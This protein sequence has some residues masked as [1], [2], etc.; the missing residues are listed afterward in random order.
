MPF[1]IEIEPLALSA[2]A[3]S[4]ENL[5]EILQ[6]AGVQ[7]EAECGGQGIC[8][9]CAAILLDGV[10]EIEGR[11]V[12][13]GIIKTCQAAVCGDAR[14]KI[15]DYRP[16]SGGKDYSV[17]PLEELHFTV[18]GEFS[19]LT[20]IKTFKLDEPTLEANESDWG[21]L[22][23]AA[24]LRENT[25][26]SLSVL[27]RL[28]Q[29][30]RAEDGR[31]S[32]IISGKSGEERIIDIRA[33]DRV[34]NYGI[35][36]DIGTTTIALHLVDLADGSIVTTVS[37]YNGQ[38]LCGA[39]V[40][41]RIIYAGRQDRLAELRKKAVDTVNNLINRTVTDRNI[42]REEIMAV[43][44]A[45][46][47]TM[48]HLFLGIAPGNIRLSPYV[49]AVKNLPILCAGELNLAVNPQALVYIAPA[50]G[51]YVGGDI[52]AGVSAVE[53]LEHKGG[54]RLFIDVGTNG[55]LVLIGDK[56]MIGCACSAG[57][58]FEGAGISC[59]MRAAEGAVEGVKI[60]AEK[61]KIDLRI[62]GSGK[63][64]GICGSGLIELTAELF[65]NGI[66]ARDG[67]FTEKSF[68]QRIKG[69]GGRKRF[70]LLT[71]KENPGGGDI[72]F[73][74]HDIAN[75]IRAKAAIFSAILFLLKMTKLTF[76]EIEKFYIAGG[77]GRSLNIARAQEIGM[78]PLIPE[79]KFVYLGNSSL[80]GAYYALLYE[81][82]RINLENIAKSM[83][84]LDLCS[85]PGYMDEFIAACFLPH[86]EG[87]LFK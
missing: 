81:G 24:G 52:T 87:K 1:R 47:T 11:K 14:L 56:W 3:E 61:E 74:E 20:K 44:F 67:K 57:P 13:E 50:V 78:L 85:M 69:E 45:G 19:P 23:R 68:N 41:S 27:Q 15:T 72:S 59:G 32:L 37:D 26:C 77:F 36:C 40:I 22:T 5:L 2:E 70:C 43:V 49:P 31:V 16:Y 39:D 51:S 54:V 29:A 21:R 65:R 83:T 17:L 75:I 64:K 28:P 55:E 58:A 71:E 84:Y 80:T 82:Q 42:R 73:S 53:L 8:E 66:I 62:I 38:I 12:E 46:N 10:C 6:K 34:R 33:G 4:G 7:I 48:A 9:T 60:E 76:T 18:P 79:E 86:T 25:I 35:A 30:V 63:A